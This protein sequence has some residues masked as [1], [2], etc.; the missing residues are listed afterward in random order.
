[1][2]IV[3]AIGVSSTRLVDFLHSRCVLV[4]ALERWHV[5]IGAGDFVVHIGVGIL[6]QA[7]PELDHA[8]DA[9]GVD[10]RVFEV[11]AGSEE[12]RFVEEHDEILDSFVVLVGIGLLAQR[13]HDR[14]L[15]V[16]FKLEG[17]EDGNLVTN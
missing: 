3:R 15:G 9:A 8:V 2:T 7:E 5:V 13:L 4:I 11:E 10:L 1:M 17:G 16:D 6:V 12:R 14:V